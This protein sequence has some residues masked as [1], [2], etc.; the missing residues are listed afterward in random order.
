MIVCKI[1]CMCIYTYLKILGLLHLNCMVINISIRV[2]IHTYIHTHIHTGQPNVRLFC[3]HFVHGL[4]VRFLF[5]GA[6][7]HPKSRHRM[8]RREVIVQ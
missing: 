7:S 6:D 5:T 8:L 3:D 4:V 1:A 2:C